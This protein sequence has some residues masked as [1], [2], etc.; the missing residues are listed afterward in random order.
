M[1][2]EILRTH[3]GEW[4]CQDYCYV[5]VIEN[6]HFKMDYIDKAAMK[7]DTKQKRSDWWSEISL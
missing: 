1:A 2:P 4:K 6:I 3:E 7:G 5:S